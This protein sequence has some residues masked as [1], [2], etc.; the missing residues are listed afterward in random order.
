[1]AKPTSIKSESLMTIDHVSEFCGV[2][3]EDGPA[4]DLR[5]G[6]LPAAKLGNQWRVRP[7]DL[8]DFVRDRLVR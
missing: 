1:M 4:L 2:S 3:V 6:E 7:R 5:A 8:D